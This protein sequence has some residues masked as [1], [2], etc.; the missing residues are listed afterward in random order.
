MPDTRPSLPP[1]G[2]FDGG[3]DEPSRLDPDGTSMCLQFRHNRR[4]DNITRHGLSTSHF[5]C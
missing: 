2:S 3:A 4:I 1:Q 5:L